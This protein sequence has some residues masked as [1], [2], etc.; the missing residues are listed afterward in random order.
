MP[1][2]EQVLTIFCDAFLFDK[3]HRFHFRPE[4]R[5]TDIYKGTTGPIADE[6]QTERFAMRLEQA[7]G[8]RLTERFSEHTTYGTSWPWL[9]QR[10][11]R[12]VTH[13]RRA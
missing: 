6:L 7:F 9:S 2:V 8:V 3:R 4:D 11:L 13:A 5:I 12:Q 1:T 10:T